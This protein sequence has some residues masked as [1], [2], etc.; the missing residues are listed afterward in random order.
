MIAHATIAG[1]AIKRLALDARS[2]VPHHSIATLP[3]NPH[4]AVAA[5]IPIVPATVAP[6]APTACGA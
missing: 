3:L 4:S 2:A 5:L 6:L 1:G